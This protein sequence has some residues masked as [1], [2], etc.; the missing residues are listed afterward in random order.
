VAMSKDFASV[1]RSS[2]MALLNQ[3][4]YSGPVRRHASTRECW[5]VRGVWRGA[6]TPWGFNT[7]DVMYL[8]CIRLTINQEKIQVELNKKWSKKDLS[9]LIFGAPN[10]VW[11]GTLQTNHSQKF[12]GSLRY[13]SPDCLMC[14]RTVWWA[15]G[16][17]ANWRQRSTAKAFCGTL[18]QQKSECRSQKAPDWV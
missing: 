17:T 13:N 1:G 4:K 12:Q 16:A 3:R 14:H 6:E 2:M 18:P 10:T 15:S 8:R 7:L 5:S 9:V 11:P